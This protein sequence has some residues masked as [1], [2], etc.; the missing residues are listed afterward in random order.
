MIHICISK[1]GQFENYGRV[2]SVA[3]TEAPHRCGFELRQ[4]F[5]I[6]SCEEAMKGR[7]FYTGEPDIFLQ[8]WKQ[9][10]LLND[11]YSV[12]ATYNATKAWS[13]HEWPYMNQLTS[14]QCPRSFVTD[15]SS[16]PRSFVTDR[17]SCPRSFV[18]DRISL[19]E[20][21]SDALPI[22][23]NGGDKLQR[24]LNEI[25]M[26]SINTNNKNA[27]CCTREL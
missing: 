5:W 21:K 2:V 19:I 18:T 20:Y 4:E 1:V 9:E 7:W 13:D 15:R 6:V 22:Y 24:N 12:G 8:Q 26:K 11:L 17:S 23:L 16:C 25:N 10:K 27:E 3:D 14:E